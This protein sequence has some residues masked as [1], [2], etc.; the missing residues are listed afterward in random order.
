MDYPEIPVCQLRHDLLICYTLT[1]RPPRAKTTNSQNDYNP[2]EETKP[3]QLKTPQKEER[4]TGLMKKGTI[5]RMKTAI[6]ALISIAEPK[7]VK[8]PTKD[9]HF[10]FKH[11]FITLTLPAPQRDITDQQITREALKPLL[12]YLKDH[13]AVLSP[14]DENGRSTSGSAWRL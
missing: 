11:N 14:C 12:E 7:T 10:T 3:Q 9:Y 1:E 6:D 5:K 13:F 8:H 2:P 4:Y